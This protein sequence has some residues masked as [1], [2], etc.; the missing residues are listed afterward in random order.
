MLDNMLEVHFNGESDF[1]FLYFL[2]VN[3]I[4]LIHAT[5]I[6]K[7]CFFFSIYAYYDNSNLTKAAIQ[8]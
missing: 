6:K 8:K 2:C 1:I 3:Y 7:D 4:N 5:Q